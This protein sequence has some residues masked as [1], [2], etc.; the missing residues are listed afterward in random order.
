[1]DIDR[2]KFANLT[3]AD[4][5]QIKFV[6]SNQNIQ[7]KIYKNLPHNSETSISE[8]E[9]ISSSTLFIK[10]YKDRGKKNLETVQ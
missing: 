1:M 8:E 4:I 5:K 2:K 7:N 3:D 10:K 6:V 9:K